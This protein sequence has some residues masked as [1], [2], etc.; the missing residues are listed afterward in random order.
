MTVIGQCGVCGGNVVVPTEWWSVVPPP[1]ACQSC[2]ARPAGPGQVMDMVP[3]PPWRT[4]P[5][6]W[7]CASS[8]DCG[9]DQEYLC[10]PEDFS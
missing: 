4:S 1:V 3:V 5:K 8:L 2:G 9:D 10:T 7:R 6:N